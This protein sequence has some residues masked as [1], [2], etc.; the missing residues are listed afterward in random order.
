[1]S[2]QT[3]LFNQNARWVKQSELIKLLRISRST[4]W[5]WR[6]YKLF[7]QPIQIGERTQ[8]WNLND[9]DQWIVN[10]NNNRGSL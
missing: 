10:S 1:M 3:S 5:R 4:L 2:T 6:R 7:P 8:F 9:I